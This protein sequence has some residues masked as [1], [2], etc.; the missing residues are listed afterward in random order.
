MGHWVFTVCVCVCCIQCFFSQLRS[1]GSETFDD[2]SW[3]WNS[4]KLVS[5][6]VCLMALRPLQWAYYDSIYDF[7]TPRT[8]CKRH[9][10]NAYQTRREKKWSPKRYTS[11]TKIHK[12]NIRRK[13]I[14]TTMIKRIHKYFVSS[15]HSLITSL[16]PAP[17]FTSRAQIYQPFY[18]QSG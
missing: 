8:I 9:I 7:N 5:F 6:C 1:L 13:T 15:F 16:Q 12:S 2:I 14:I 3:H 4:H 10:W 11:I 18:C 17:I